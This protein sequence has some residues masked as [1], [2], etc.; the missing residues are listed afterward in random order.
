M[1][2]TYNAVP[3]NVIAKYATYLNI[4]SR[5]EGK[6]RAMSTDLIIMGY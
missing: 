3:A 6:D 1:E 2:A 4:K 5:F